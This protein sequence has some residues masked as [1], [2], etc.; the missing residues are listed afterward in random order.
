MDEQVDDLFNAEGTD[1]ELANAV[2]DLIEQLGDEAA[3][4]MFSDLNMHEIRQIA[5]MSMLEDDVTQE[6]IKNYIV[7]K[8]SHKRKGRKELINIGESLGSMI[9]TDEERGWR[10][11]IK[12][13][14]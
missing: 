5:A 12:G 9:N 2:S 3:T 11:K 13:M 8:V 1:D 7:F 10:D 4:Q 14:M 6:F